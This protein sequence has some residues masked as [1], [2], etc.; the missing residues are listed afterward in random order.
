M[1][2]IRS[3]YVFY[4]GVYK[5]VHNPFLKFLIFVFIFLFSVLFFIIFL[6]LCFILIIFS[7]IIIPLH[8]ILRRF[9][10]NGFFYNRGTHSGFYLKKESLKIR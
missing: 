9:G 8:F 1:Q 10:K 4:K 3:F 6:F 5:E 2:T 7:P